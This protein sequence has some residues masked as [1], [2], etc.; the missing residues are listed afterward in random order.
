M[1]ARISGTLVEQHGSTA[2]ID[3]GG[4]GYAVHLSSNTVGSLS[5][6]GETVSLWTHLSVRENALDLYGFT[7]RDELELFELLIGV[8]GIGPKSG[9]AILSLATVEEL[10]TSI[11]SGD[12]AYL[13]TVSGIG[14]K[15]AEKIVLEL[16]DK[17]GEQSGAAGI[18]LSEE[19]DVLEA[20]G[21][22]GYSVR[23]SREVLRHVPR[24]VAGTGERVRV[25]LK[26]LGTKR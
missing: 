22:L 5:R 21:A 23:E 11:R 1:I 25:A 6:E 13:T 24:A 7:E 10:A 15:S 3:V 4:V 14:K 16:R 12:T 20:L 18:N 2:T 17:L 9:L 19:T 8:P 26:L